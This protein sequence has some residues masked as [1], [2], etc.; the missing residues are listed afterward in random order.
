MRRQLVGV[1]VCLGVLGSGV[2]QGQIP[3][4]SI[5]GGALVPAGEY[6][7]HDRTGWHAMVAFTPLGSSSSL[8]GLRFDGLYG[9]TTRKAPVS[10]AMSQVFGLDAS[11]ILRPRGKRAVV[12]YALG[13]LGYYE[14]EEGNIGGGSSPPVNGLAVGGGVG[15][16]FGRGRVRLF[17]EGRVIGGPARHG[18]VFIPITLGG[19]LSGG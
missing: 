4:W 8:F 9:R 12:P 7:L 3:R 5:G 14:M 19:T 15:L 2:A 11:I 10:A 1:T 17:L 18:V 13:G 6:S 16:S